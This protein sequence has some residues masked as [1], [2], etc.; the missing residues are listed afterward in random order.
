M[1]KYPQCRPAR[2]RAKVL[3]LINSILGDYLEGRIDADLARRRLRYLIA[4]NAVNG[5]APDEEVRALVARALGRVAA[6]PRSRVRA[7]ER[8]RRRAVLLYA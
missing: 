4:L 1:V 8:E 6:A 5:W 2:G 7:R 3:C